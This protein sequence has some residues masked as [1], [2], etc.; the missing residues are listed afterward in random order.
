MR[1]PPWPCCVIGMRLLLAFICAILASVFNLLED[2]NQP[3]TGLY[4]IST[5]RLTV[6]ESGIRGYLTLAGGVMPET[7]PTVPQATA[8]PGTQESP[9][10]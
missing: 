1:R 8:R 10:S 3:F 9:A 7:D 2:M 6:V 5:R 4:A